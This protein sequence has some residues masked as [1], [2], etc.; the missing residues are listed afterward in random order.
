MPKL[1]ERR[2][3]D[4]KMMA[5]TLAQIATECGATAEIENKPFGDMSP[6]MVMVRVT[7]QRGLQCAFEFDGESLQPDTFVN[8][9]NFD[10]DSDTCLADS[11]PGSVNNYHFRKSTTS[12]DGFE[13]LCDHVRDVC[14]KAAAGS[15]FDE[16]RERN[17]VAENGTWQERKARFQVWRE[18]MESCS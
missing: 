6:K 4:R 16:E 18:Q 8:A 5:E 1:T 14:T 9:W 2:A 13:A 12:V 15:I 17:H 10:T 11:F 3:A 7:C